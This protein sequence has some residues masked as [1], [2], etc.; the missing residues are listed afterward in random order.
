MLRIPARHRYE[1]IRSNCIDYCCCFVFLAMDLGQFETSYWPN[2][3][4][5][6]PESLA[7]ESG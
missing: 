2:D 5:I 3:G 4:P 1:I 6:K 7:Y